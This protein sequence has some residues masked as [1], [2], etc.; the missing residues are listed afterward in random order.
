MLTPDESRP[1]KI[2]A[3]FLLLLAGPLFTGYVPG[4]K[5]IG[6]SW[7][8]AE[9]LYAMFFMPFVL[10]RWARESGTPTGAGELPWW[11]ATLLVASAGL[12][13]LIGLFAHI[14]LWALGA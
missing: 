12:G 8:F 6:G 13:G 7:A 11:L 14:E 9:L 5:E 2:S 4:A 10:Y 3:L 1:I